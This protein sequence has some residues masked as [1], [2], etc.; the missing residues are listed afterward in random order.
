MNELLF[1]LHVGLI[2]AFALGALRLG[3]E[4]LVAW[5]CIQSILA[6]VFVIKQMDFLG[7][8]ITCSDVFAIGAILGLNLIQEY[9]GRESAKKTTSICLFF[10]LFFTVMSKMQLLYVPSKYDYAQ[11]AYH[12]ILSP[13]AR[14]LFASLFT[15][16][17]VQKIDV[18]F[19]Q[20][21]REKLPHYPLALRSALTIV[22][23]QAI[24]TTLFSFLGLYGLVSSIFDIILI[25]FLIKVLII[26]MTTP[27][28]LFSKKMVRTS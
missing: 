25:S 9:F 20:Y 12:T 22:L 18:K 7:F 27:L 5:V 26:L 15:F 6:N 10:M 21:I 24:D 13:A 11:S 14:I 17:L 4:T 16:F 23:S 19:F 3:K 2:I 28:V 8:T 1:F